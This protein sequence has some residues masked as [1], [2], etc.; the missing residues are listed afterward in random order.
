MMNNLNV[1]YKYEIKLRV[2]TFNM[3]NL[4]ISIIKDLG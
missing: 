3:Y 4:C 2:Y 1:L